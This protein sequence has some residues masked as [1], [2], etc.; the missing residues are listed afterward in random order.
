MILSTVILLL[1]IISIVHGH[2]VGVLSMIISVATYAISYFG[3][4]VSTP[5]IGGWLTKLF[6]EIGHGTTTVSGSSLS[7][8]DL[9]QFFYRGIAFIIC[10]IILNVIVRLLLR[11]LKWFTK[12]PILGTVDRWAGA[13]LDFVICYVIIFVLLVVFQLY[14]GGW[15]QMQ[16]ANSDVAQLII[17]ETPFLTE[18]L[19]NL[20]G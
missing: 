19:I 16:L 5:I 18:T 8:L 3:A 12:L 6:P 14:P 15:W 20:L 10:F 7:G 9:S 11:K 1:L 2:R 13:I 17:K 4:K